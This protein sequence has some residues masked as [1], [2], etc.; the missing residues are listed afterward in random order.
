M[1]MMRTMILTIIS[2]EYTRYLAHD[3]LSLYSD[4]EFENASLNSSFCLIVNSFS[5]QIATRTVLK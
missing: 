4:D 3:S 1:E 2:Y 5:K